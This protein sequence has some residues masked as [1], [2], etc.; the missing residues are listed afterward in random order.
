MIGKDGNHAVIH[1]Y[2]TKNAL[3]I[4]YDL[5]LNIFACE[6][7]FQLQIFT[8]SMQIAVILIQEITSMFSR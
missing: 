6:Y 4:K 8:L 3:P 1:T 7:V 5:G 2:S